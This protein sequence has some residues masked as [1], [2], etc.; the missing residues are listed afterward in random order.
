MCQSQNQLNLKLTQHCT[1]DEF[2]CF[3][4]L[5]L[6]EMSRIPSHNRIADNEPIMVSIKYKIK[7]K[8]YSIREVA[9]ILLVSTYIWS[10][11]RY[12]L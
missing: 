9:V 11:S 4:T 5:S 10:L 12:L 2:K 7:Y 1:I 6:L 8:Y 3:S